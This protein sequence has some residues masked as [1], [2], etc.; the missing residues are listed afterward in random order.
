MDQTTTMLVTRELVA[1]ASDS[2]SGVADAQPGNGDFWI[3]ALVHIVA[4]DDFPD[5]IAVDVLVQGAVQLER[6][7][8]PEY[9]HQA[10][11]KRLGVDLPTYRRL[12]ADPDMRA[13]VIEQA[14]TVAIWRDFV[15]PAPI[16]DI[17]D[18]KPAPPGA[19]YSLQQA[20][21]PLPAPPQLRIDTE[22]YRE[23]RKWGCSVA[24]AW[25][26]STILPSGHSGES[27]DILIKLVLKELRVNEHE[28]AELMQ[29]G[30]QI[31]MAADRRYRHDGGKGWS[32]YILW[33]LR[34]DLRKRLK[35]LRRMGYTGFKK[36]E[37][38]PTTYSLSNRV[39]RSGAGHAVVDFDLED[40]SKYSTETIETA[41]RQGNYTTPPTASSYDGWPADHDDADVGKGT[42]ALRAVSQP[43][44][45][46][47]DQTDKAANGT[48]KLV[49]KIL[50]NRPASDRN[51]LV[52]AFGLG[53]PE[54][55]VTELVGRGWPSRTTAHRHLKRALSRA[56]DAILLSDQKLADLTGET[57][58]VRQMAV[59][60][61]LEVLYQPPKRWRTSP[62]KNGKLV[63][64]TVR[65]SGINPTIVWRDNVWELLNTL[66]RLSQLETKLT[67]ELGALLSSHVPTWREGEHRAAVAAVRQALQA[68]Q[69]IRDGKFKLDVAAAN[70][71]A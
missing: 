18:I 34:K 42:P 48:E 40:R 2:L 36:G 67:Q 31:V 15:L 13:A 23:L 21:P 62:V 52:L 29:E 44:S 69:R 32:D 3:D 63:T 11:A 60:N 17:S 47:E 30:Q 61:C 6:L 26:R 53:G 20:A 33:G 28:A 59:L 1:T 37:F 10:I 8:I 64:G 14:N 58:P 65:E 16:A 35:K 5:G 39:V 50:R 68:L 38:P 41:F 57:D 70:K 51:I 12:L 19:V 7:A 9:A 22:K 45:A 27:A 66:T 55:S 54:C 56:R 49:A 4:A 25:W 43:R 24:S 71:A 46:V